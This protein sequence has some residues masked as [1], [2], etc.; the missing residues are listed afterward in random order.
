MDRWGGGC[1]CEGI[2]L[3]AGYLSKTTAG[4]EAPYCPHTFQRQKVLSMLQIAIT[5]RWSCCTWA[6]L[7]GLRK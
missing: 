6:Y 3:L 4:S 2:S 1:N 7:L 5:C